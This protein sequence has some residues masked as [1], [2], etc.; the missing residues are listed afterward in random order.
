MG[1]GRGE[2]FVEGDVGE[3]EKRG[4]SR[5]CGGDIKEEDCEEKSG[6]KGLERRLFEDKISQTEDYKCQCHCSE[7]ANHTTTTATTTTTTMTTR[8]RCNR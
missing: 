3:G 4:K 5:M 6:R 2:D 8:S 7:L 1:E